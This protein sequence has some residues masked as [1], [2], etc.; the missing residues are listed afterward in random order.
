MRTQTNNYSGR[1]EYTCCKNKACVQSSMRST[2]DCLTILH[3]F[4]LP[5]GC[6]QG[7]WRPKVD[8]LEPWGWLG[9]YCVS[10][11]NQLHCL[12][13]IWFRKCTGSVPPCGTLVETDAAGWASLELGLQIPRL[14]CRWMP[15]NGSATFHLSPAVLIECPQPCWHQHFLHSGLYNRYFG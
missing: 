12:A 14:W 2:Y 11:I 3:T 8:C 6:E 4:F 1:I 15:L 10:G 7:N 9:D 5:K 13:G